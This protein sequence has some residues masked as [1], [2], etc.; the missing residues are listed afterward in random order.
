M[1]FLSKEEN[2]SKSLIKNILEG[3]VTKLQ[4]IWH[5]SDLTG[6]H[7]PWTA[8]VAI[9]SGSC[10]RILSCFFLGRSSFSLVFVQIQGC[11][12]LYLKVNRLSNPFFCYSS[13]SIGISRKWV[14]KYHFVCTC[15]QSQLI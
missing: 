8:S 3:D 10:F 6:S 2:L 12:D 9:T 5:E 15:S 7:F 11:P 1:I 14:S 4:K 13:R